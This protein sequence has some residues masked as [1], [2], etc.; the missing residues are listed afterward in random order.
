MQWLYVDVGNTPEKR[1]AQHPSSIRQ[2]SE[3]LHHTIIQRGAAEH[4][5]PL[6]ANVG[7][8]QHREK[9]LKPHR[10]AEMKQ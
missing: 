4:A 3:N 8:A 2:G 10:L 5:E 6:D 1:F 7:V 9:G